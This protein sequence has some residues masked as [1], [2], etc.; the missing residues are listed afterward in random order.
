VGGGEHC[1]TN[2]LTE[3]VGIATLLGFDENRR[4]LTASCGPYMSF[5]LKLF[6]IFYL[7]KDTKNG[8]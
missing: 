4:F 8:F 5:A 1:G 7:K 2:W 6:P 3:V